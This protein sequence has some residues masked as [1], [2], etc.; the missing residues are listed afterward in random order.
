MTRSTKERVAFWEA[1]ISEWEKSG[2][3]REKFFQ[4]EGLNRSTAG[5]WFRKLQRKGDGE[6]FVEITST[7]VKSVSRE[8]LKVTV[9]GKYTIEIGDNNFNRAI[10]SEVVKILEAF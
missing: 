2:L 9:R 5:Y 7:E 10:F 3:S 4:K 1:K 6:G 8:S